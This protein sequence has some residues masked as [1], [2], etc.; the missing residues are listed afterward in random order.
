MLLWM[1]ISVFAVIAVVSP[2]DGFYEA[3]TYYVFFIEL[4][5][6]DAI[7]IPQNARGFFKTAALIFR[8]VNLR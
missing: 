8:Q 4:N 1:Y 3:V 6:S 5:M 7:D 2:Y